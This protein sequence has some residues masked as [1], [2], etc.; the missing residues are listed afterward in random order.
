LGFFCFIVGLNLALRAVIPLPLSFGA[1]P[2]G[3][4]APSAF[5]HTANNIHNDTTALGNANSH[6]DVQTESAR[7]ARK[8]FCCDLCQKGYSRINEFEAHEGS[9]DH[10]HKKVGAVLF[11]GYLWESGIAFVC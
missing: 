9:Y 4:H 7:E 11:I 2:H 6:V 8:S 1:L 10:Q 5:F 3:H